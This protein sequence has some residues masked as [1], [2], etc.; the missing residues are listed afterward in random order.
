MHSNR[1]K[2]NIIQHL[3]PL[4]D[5]SQNH[6]IKQRVQWFTCIVSNYVKLFINVLKLQRLP[7]YMQ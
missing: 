6:E 4:S 7:D 2:I 3:E 5:R 1:L